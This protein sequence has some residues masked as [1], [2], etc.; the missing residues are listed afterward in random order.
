[1]N[2]ITGKRYPQH[3]WSDKGDGGCYKKNT[4]RDPETEA[5]TAIASGIFD[6]FLAYIAD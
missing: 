6:N 4:S 3:N 5:T 2:F 1:M